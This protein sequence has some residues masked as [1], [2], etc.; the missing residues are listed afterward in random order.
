MGEVSGWQQVANGVHHLPALRG[1]Q[2][3]RMRRGKR[4]AVIVEILAGCIRKLIRKCCTHQD[5]RSDADILA[6]RAE[7]PLNFSALSQEERDALLSDLMGR[8]LRP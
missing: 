1:V 4:A 8:Q 6:G 5:V 2:C 7:R 3:V